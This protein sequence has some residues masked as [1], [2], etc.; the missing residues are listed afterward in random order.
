MTG[1]LS[2]LWGSTAPW[3]K[4]TLMLFMY[5]GRS[6]RFSTLTGRHINPAVQNFQHIIKLRLNT[7][8]ISR[9]TYTGYLPHKTAC[10]L[11]RFQKTKPHP[12]VGIPESSL[13]V[14]G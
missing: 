5:P 3:L 14:H 12:R 6:T 4:M 2:A 1:P 13:Y 7:S 9:C 11:E 10:R 8:R